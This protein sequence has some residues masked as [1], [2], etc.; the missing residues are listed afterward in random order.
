MHAV[1]LAGSL[2]VDGKLDE[3]AWETAPAATNFTQSYPNPGARPIDSTSVRVVYDDEAIYVGIRMFDAH[4]DSIAAQLAPHDASAIYSDW[5]HLIIDS[6]HDRRTA[7][8]FSANPLGVQKDVYTFNDG[9]EDLNWD[10]VWQVAARIDSLGWVAEYRIPLS[11]LRFGRDE[12]R[13]ERTWGLQIMRDI[14][15]RNER[16]VWSPWTPQSAGFVSDFGDLDGLG[17]IRAARRLQVLPYMSMEMTRAPGVAGDPFHRATD[18]R[19]SG[20][21]DVRFGLPAGITVTATLHPDFGQ[22]EA[23]PAV[24]NLT[25]FETFFPEKRPFFLEGSDVFNFGQVVQRN[26]FGTQYFFYSRRVG[27]PPELSPAGNVVYAAVPEQTSIVG[28]AKMTGTTGPW[29]VGLLDAVSAQATEDVQFAGGTRATVPVEPLTNFLAGRLKRDF[30]Q[31]ASFVGGMLTSTTRAM[32]DSTFSSVLHDNATFGGIDFEHSVRHR[33]WILSGLAAASRVNGSREA[34]TATEANSTHGL[35]RPDGSYLGYDTTRTTLRG[36]VDEI[37]LEKTG[38]FEGSVAY[39]EMNPGFELN[40]LGFLGRADYR[41]LSTLVGYQNHD[42]GVR[43]QNFLVT[44]ATNNAWN[45]GGRDILR[46]GS[47]SGSVN[48]VNQWS[49]SLTAGRTLSAY[50]DR[51]LRGG[52]LALTLPGWNVSGSIGTDARRPVIVTLNASYQKDRAGTDNP[53]FGLGLDARPTGAVHLT[54]SPTWTTELSRTQYVRAVPDSDAATY[55]TRYVLANL[56]Q[57]TLDLEM[58]LDWTLSTSLSLQTYLQPFVSSGA[59]SGFKEFL[60]PGTLAF[61]AYGKDRGAI[62]FD[63][64]SDTYTVTPNA[65]SSSAFTFRNP[66]FN[67][68]SLRGNAVLR[69]DYRPGSTLYVVW[70]QR[71]SDESTAIGFATGRDV[72][73]IFRSAPTNVLLIKATYWLER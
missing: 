50:D 34:I 3:P 31:G 19:V 16:D 18:T 68:R 64:A 2:V 12:E 44:V 25:A 60:Q 42:A 33:T 27:R 65:P 47:A 21:A 4:P 61:A 58:R 36:Y 46:E 52:P 8:R 63:A 28:A 71:R 48:F 43:A 73:A 5:I 57:K 56:R 6:Y 53:S 70:Q 41:A 35:Q 59:Y 23:D 40:D 67:N 11:Q 9:D 1:R 26:D 51:L 45:F 20:G 54:I 62:A 72:G 39:K 49:A 22:V 10:A 15:R 66:D 55:G 69:W 7:F 13:A 24:V 38:A 30:R 29:T 37:A 17:D 32:S 14:A